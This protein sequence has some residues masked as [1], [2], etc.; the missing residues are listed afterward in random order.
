[1]ADFEPGKHVVL[2]DPTAS[3]ALMSGAYRTAKVTGTSGV[4]NTTVITCSTLE[5][6]AG[7][8]LVLS[9]AADTQVTLKRSTLSGTTF[10]DT[11]LF[12]VDLFADVNPFILPLVPNPTYPWFK[13]GTNEYL[14]IATSVTTCSLN[15]SV[16]FYKGT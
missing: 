14:K 10:T 11:D 8:G 5:F 4:V 3:K 7:M 16:I 1:M 15:G 2:W 6:I 9:V 12:S 13:T